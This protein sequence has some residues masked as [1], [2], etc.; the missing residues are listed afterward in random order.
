[1]KAKQ[2]NLPRGSSRPGAAF[3]LA[4]ALRVHHWLKNLLLAVPLITSHNLTDRSLLADTLLAIIAFNLAASCGYLVNDFL[5]LEA[6]R[7]H[8]VKRRRPLAA[9]S[10]L[11]PLPKKT[12]T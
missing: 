2:P 10:P 3:H 8:P 5:D 12:R 7:R 9:G 4:Q 1:M 11:H 6:D